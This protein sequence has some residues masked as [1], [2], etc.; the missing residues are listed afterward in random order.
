[1]KWLF[2]KSY[3][4]NILI[5]A[6][7]IISIIVTIESESQ[8]NLL[9]TVHEFENDFKEVVSCMP[10]YIMFKENDI[11]A[12]KAFAIVQNCYIN[13]LDFV[14]NFDY[15]MSTLIFRKD[16]RRLQHMLNDVVPLSVSSADVL[17]GKYNVTWFFSPA[18][19]GTIVPTRQI[20]HDIH[21][22]FENNIQMFRIIEHCNLAIFLI[23]TYF[24]FYALKKQTNKLGILNTE[25]IVIN[26]LCHELRTSLVPVTMYSRELMNKVDDFETKQ[27]INNKIMTS[28]H[29]H[30][31]VLMSR[32]DFD[33]ILK[34]R[35]MIQLVDMN[36]ITLLNEYI[37]DLKQYCLL[38]EKN[39]NLSVKTHQNHLFMKLDTMILRYIVYNLTR[40][41]IKYSKQGG[42]IVIE[43]YKKNKDVTIIIMDDGP[44]ISPVHL[45]ELN[46]KII[47]KESVSTRRCSV[48]NVDSYGMGIKFTK[49]LVSIINDATFEITSE[50]L[51]KGCVNKITIPFIEPDKKY[52]IERLSLNEL[53]KCIVIC[54]TDDCPIVLRCMKM[55]L[56]KLF[57]N[58]EIVCFSSGEELLEYS[59]TNNA[60]YIHI[61]DE[62]IQNIKGNMKGSDIASILKQ[63][64]FSKN[65]Q[66]FTIS[67]SGSDLPKNALHY[68]DVVWDKPP[69]PHDTI[70]S[71]IENL[72]K[73]HSKSS[74]ESSQIQ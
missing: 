69:P 60:K 26:Q 67:M 70:K 59:F 24:Y 30:E 52:C 4:I 42:N 2:S 74:N 44:G 8:V 14:L 20:F 6:S 21:N 63:R 65:E 11:Q 43:I 61:L 13:S 66:H 31:Y 7:I 9:H 3:F 51:N 12:T 71:D 56:Q 17:D 34:N 64:E 18:V 46:N 45:V 36:I 57:T 15:K 35:Y 40:N 29:Q 54:I 55:T 47:T 38:C 22:E 33:K 53:H 73:R 62:N 50:G 41:S 49:K 23:L 37:A 10:M 19:G 27:F 48:Q 58:A 5:T 68:F 25:T 1:M 16:I 72:L 39:V 32:L 28:I